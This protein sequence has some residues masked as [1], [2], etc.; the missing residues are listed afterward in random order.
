MLLAAH[1]VM[2]RRLLVVAQLHL[3]LLLLLR[4]LACVKVRVVIST[5]RVTSV[6]GETRLFRQSAVA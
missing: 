3:L 1:A 5:A 4:R 6:V 2:Q